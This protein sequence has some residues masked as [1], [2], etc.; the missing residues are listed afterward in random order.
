MTGREG[1]T[2]RRTG[3]RPSADRP[4][5][6]VKDA[7]FALRT[8]PGRIIRRPAEHPARVPTALVLAA[9]SAMVATG[10]IF[11]LLSRPATSPVSAPPTPSA[12][13]VPAQPRAAPHAQPPAK[14]TPSSVAHAFVDA[15]RHRA[16]PR[17]ARLSVGE[18]RDAVT[19]KQASDAKLPA[20]ER[21]SAD[22]TWQAL[23][24]APLELETISLQALP[25]GSVHL[26]AVAAYRLLAH[27]YRREVTLRLRR[28]DGHWRVENMT[29]GA[30]LTALPRLLRGAPEAGH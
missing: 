29:L 9:S 28:V 27:P 22:A 1:M 4:K 20:A 16:W 2:A 26:R 17:A 10:F 8:P 14:S 3:S 13:L 19:R 12:P 24:S 11:V 7:R 15:W 30:L 21:A 6:S 23:A 5:R 25:G 18:A